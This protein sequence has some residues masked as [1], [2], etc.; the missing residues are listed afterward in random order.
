MCLIPTLSSAYRPK[1]HLFKQNVLH[2]HIRKN[3]HFLILLNQIFGNL[4]L[5]RTYKICVVKTTLKMFDWGN[6]WPFCFDKWTKTI[7]SFFHVN[8]YHIRNKIR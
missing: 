2:A 6:I 8:D 1:Y 7:I 3:T 4:E 5:E